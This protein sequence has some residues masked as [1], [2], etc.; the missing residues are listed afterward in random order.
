MTFGSGHDRTPLLIGAVVCVL[1]LELTVVL[2]WPTAYGP[3]EIG[4]ELLVT[5]MWAVSSFLAWRLRPERPMGSLMLLFTLILAIVGPVGLGLQDRGWVSAAFTTVG[6][7]LVPFQTA[8]GAHLL[9]AFPSGRLPRGLARGLVGVVYGYA[10]VEALT[11]L[12][13]TPRRQDRCNGPCGENLAAVSDVATYLRLTELLALGWLPLAMC[14][15]AAVVLRYLRIGRRERRIMTPALVA[16]VVA[17]SAYVYLDLF[18]VSHGGRNAFGAGPAPELVGIVVL[19]LA[20]LAIPLC[21]LLGLLRERLAYSAV[22]D[23]L[24]E[25][26]HHVPDE[27]DLTGVLARTLGDPTLRIVFPVRGRLLNVAGAPVTPPPGSRV[28]LVGEP[29]R[30]PLALLVHEAS[31]QEEPDLLAAAGSALRLALDNARLHA[32]VAAQLAEVHASRARIVAAADEARRQIERDLHDGAQQ[33]LL[34]AGLALQLARLQ[35]DSGEHADLLDDAEHEISEALKELR[36]LA[37]GIHPAVL[38]DQGLRPALRALACRCTIPV[39]IVGE[40]AGHMPDIVQTVAYFCVSEAITNAIKHAG[41]A[42]IQV[43]LHRSDSLLTVTIHDDGCGGAD[44]NG[45]G[46]RGLADRVA[47]VGGTF[48]VSS[49]PS[50]GTRLTVEIPCA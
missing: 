1:G 30:P 26:V 32:E 19:Q 18:T 38:T 36:D 21:F 10:S 43:I 40:D 7:A 48:T 16:T 12:L 5:A 23:L 37:A 4:R 44:P 35:R 3:W 31:L 25:L 39:S 50:A 34:S 33:R 42:E 46:L 13:A 9:L 49:P 14:F 41:A 6:I 24:R 22:S 2:S 17:L 15:A 11:L 8:L 29:G 45:A 20:V 47:A 27:Q 28:T